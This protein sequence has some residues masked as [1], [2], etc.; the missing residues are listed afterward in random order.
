MLEFKNKHNIK[1]GKLYNSNDNGTSGQL[2]AIPLSV[3]KDKH[4]LMS[5]CK[6]FTMLTLLQWFFTP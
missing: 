3:I 2:C 4:L 5:L 1:L 6:Y